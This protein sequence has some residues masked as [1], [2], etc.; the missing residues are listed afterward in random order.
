MQVAITVLGIKDVI[1]KAIKEGCAG[2]K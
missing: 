2:K 1:T